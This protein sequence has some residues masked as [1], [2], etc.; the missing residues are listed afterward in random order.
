MN[1]GDRY[2]NWT[3]IDRQQGHKKALCLCACGAKKLVNKHN[4]TRN[5]SK[6]C[7][8]IGKH[9]RAL[10]HGLSGI[11]EYQIWKAIKARCYNKN[12][13]NYPDYGG[14]GITVC[15]EWFNNFEAFYADMGSRPG[16]RYSIDRINNEEGYFKENCRWSTQT[17]QTRNT[18][19]SRW[20]T[21]NNETR[22]VAEWAEI[23]GIRSSTIYHRLYAGCSDAEALRL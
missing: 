21:I 14:R 11:P 23:T 13:K 18:R 2:G 10:R 1:T 6:S 12:H 19:R 15:D 20:V 22:T 3:V 17:Q 16:S 7:G 4:L 9:L 5:K 8:C